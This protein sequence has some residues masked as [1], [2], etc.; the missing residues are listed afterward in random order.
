MTQQTHFQMRNIVLAFFVITA[1]LFQMFVSAT[2]VLN[3]K[4][5]NSETWL[6]ELQS[7]RVLLCTAQGLKWVSVSELMSP[8]EDSP[9]VDPNH[10]PIQFHCTLLKAGQYSL[11]LAFAVLAIIALWLNRFN[12]PLVIFEPRISRR[13]ATLM[14]APKQSPPTL[15][16]A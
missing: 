9:H 1:L 15:Y 5:F 3:P 4:Q 2:V 12:I 10:E 14:L 16:S 6:S 8:I 11:V 13:K 7:D